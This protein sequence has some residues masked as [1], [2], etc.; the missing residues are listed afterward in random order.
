MY[1]TTFYSFKGGVG[2]TMALVNAAVSLALRGRRVLVVD[3]DIEAPGLDTFD[4]LQPRTGVPGVVDF[5][6]RYLQ[7]GTAP[8]ALEYI[9][10]CPEIGAADGKLWIMPSG[11]ADAYAATLGQINWV[12]LYERHDGY[13]LF[14]DL[15]QQWSQIVQ[16]DYVLIDS[17]TGHT[18]SS[19]ICT[20]QLPDAVVILFFP[21]EQNLRGLTQVVRDI[22]SEGEEPRSKE[23]SLHFVMSNVPDLDD[24]DEILQDKMS[25][26]RKQLGFRRDPMVVHRYDS[27]SLLNQIVFSKDRPRS[28][29]AREY[30][31]IVREISAH[32]WNDRDGV[33][34]YIR[35]AG[36]RRRRFEDV[37]ILAMDDRLEKI[38]AAHSDDGEVLFRL[39]ELKE[40]D[41]QPEAAAQL[42][43]QAIQHGYDRPEAFLKRS[44]FRAENDEREG[45]IEDAGH[46]LDCNNVSP[47]MVREAIGLLTRLSERA[48][49][50]LVESNAVTSLDLSE[51]VWLAETL[52]RSRAHLPVAVALWKM[53]AAASDTSNFKYPGAQ[54]L[55]GLSHMGLGQFAEAAE[56]F[57]RPT[58]D[59]SPMEIGNMFNYG[60]AR[61]GMVGTIEAGIFE[62][63]IA[64]DE[65]GE[66][67]EE[68]ANYL[69]CM[70][71]AYWATGETDKAADRADRAERLLPT[72]R[73][74]SEFSCWRYLV[75]SAGTFKKDLDEMRAMIQEIEP[76]TLPRFMRTPDAAG[77]DP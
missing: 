13:L 67:N 62:R 39:G 3:F 32:N 9:G 64:L 15:R 34:E 47:P 44:R 71:I 38:A 42:I 18:D 21:N 57:R 73:K 51:K 60:M 11:R 56:C 54:S 35:R 25:A 4:L 6:A 46:V 58:S 17:R 49:L 69:Q 37:S 40:G 53:I 63:V 75:V 14:E 68:T 55:L 30:D 8:D 31:R 27:L 28:R 66:G 24:E 20:R 70:A 10:E 12:D 72:L 74:G 36:G 59:M 48:A 1:V 26:F 43:H 16:P 7:T 52:N 76:R 2:R 41:R 77:S 19:G 33:L 65:S 5:V 50:E 23:I 45:A 29:L 61:W 22:R